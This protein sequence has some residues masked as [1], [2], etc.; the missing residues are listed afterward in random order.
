[1]LCSKQ[2][3]HNKFTRVE[4]RTPLCSTQFPIGLSV[5]L[6][7]SKVHVQIYHKCLPPTPWNISFIDMPLSIWQSTPKLKQSLYTTMACGVEAE[8]RLFSTSAADWDDWF[9]SCRGRFIPGNNYI[10][11]WVQPRQAER[12]GAEENLLPLRKIDQWFLR[13]PARILITTLTTMS[14][15][16]VTTCTYEILC[17]FPFSSL[18]VINATNEDY[19]FNVILR[20]CVSD[21]LSLHTLNRV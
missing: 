15:L 19:R 10:G 11:D 7:T 8:L 3:L 16:C 1:M 17:I 20:L 13:F 2:N 14:L 6:H 9:A 4:R 12:L 21:L 18:N 5:I